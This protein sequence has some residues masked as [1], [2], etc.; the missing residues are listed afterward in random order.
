MNT[1]ISTAIEVDTLETEYLSNPL[2]LDTTSPRMA[3]QIQSDVNGQQQTAYRILVSSRR[4]LAESGEGDLWD[5]GKIHSDQSF[6]VEYAGQALE[7]N[8]DCYWKVKVWG[9]HDTESDWSDVARFSIGPLNAQDWEGEWI[10]NPDPAGTVMQHQWF[11]KLIDLDEAVR[12][13]FIHVCSMGYHNLY[14]NGV[15]VGELPLAPSLSRLDKRVLSVSYDVSAYL[16]AGRNKIDIQYNPGWARYEFFETTAGLL[17]DM[18]VETEG[19]ETLVFS[20][21]ES[22]RSIIGFGERIGGI[23]YRDHGGE[24]YDMSLLDAERSLLALDSTEGWNIPVKTVVKNV[25]ISADLSNPNKLIKTLKPVAIDFYEE[26]KIDMGINY[27]GM[28]EINFPA[29]SGDG[30][31]IIKIADDPV[32][33]SYGEQPPGQDFGQR[34]IIRLRPDGS[35]HFKNTFNYVSGRYITLEGLKKP[36]SKDDVSVHVLTNGFERVGSFTSSNPL[37]DEIFEV[38]LWTFIANT[39][40]GF[41]MDCPHRERLGYGEATYATA[42][43]IGLPNYKAGAFYKKFLQDWCD[44]QSENGWVSHTAPQINTHFGGTMWSS[45]PVNLAYEYFKLYGDRATIEK[46]YPTGVRWL[47]YLAEHLDAEGVLLN[48]NDANRGYFLGD[49]AA[50]GGR[51]EWGDTLEARFF[52]S[53]TFLMVTHKMAEIAEYLGRSEDAQRFQQTAAHLKT[54]I[55][56]KF[57]NPDDATYMNRTQTQLAFALW[58]DVPP[59]AERERVFK[60]FVAAMQAEPKMLD[61]GSSGLPVLLSYILEDAERADLLNPLLQQTEQPSYGH[62]LKRGETTWPEYWSVDVPSKIHTCYTG[63]AS[64]FTRGIAGITALPEHPGMKHFAIR[65]S[66]LDGLEHAATTRHSP[67]GLIQS[68]WEKSGDQF[69]LT[70]KIPVNSTAEVALPGVTD[71]ANLTVNGRPVADVAEVEMIQEIEDSIL[72]RVESGSYCFRVVL[73]Q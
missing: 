4:D 31:L 66:L 37:F 11:R 15:K 54:A 9:T 62:F 55:H 71:A 24:L 64:F 30:E 73:S 17:V 42:W 32:G 69:T 19:G 3:W 46:F 36:L 26:C 13:S 23:H 38:D 33:A 16:K 7:K 28:L 56:R 25:A 43:G 59:A 63:I 53:C 39:A 44:V 6:L 51:K 52:N 72:V 48:Y 35:G 34:N 12:K 20:T 47:A 40:E 29:G 18:H 58:Q 41:T 61:M 70:V 1:V 10:A 27:T 2:G 14:V 45:A 49:W 22:W 8:D 5:S 68:A 65:P 50:P 21:D 60:A 67:Y 57:F